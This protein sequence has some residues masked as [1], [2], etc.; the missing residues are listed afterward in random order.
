MPNR[1]KLEVGHYYRTREA[2]S[3]VRCKAH[4]GPPKTGRYI[5]TLE[6]GTTLG[7]VDEYADMQ[8][9]VAVRVKG[10]W[11]N[12]WAKRGMAEHRGVDFAR[13]VPEEEVARWEAQG[14]EH[15]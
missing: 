14:W 11:I 13:K 9:Y 4:T 15:R 7:P 12:V 10:Y 8:W 3:T 6:P 1:P 5:T 2:S